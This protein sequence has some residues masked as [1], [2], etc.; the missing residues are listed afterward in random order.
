MNNP[1]SPL[2][3]ARRR[4]RQLERCLDD[5]GRSLDVCARELFAEGR[6]A[7]NTNEFRLIA[8]LNRRIGRTVRKSPPP[9]TPAGG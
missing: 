8:Q 7:E 2:A 9:T 1:P 3:V 6:D 5:L 4:V